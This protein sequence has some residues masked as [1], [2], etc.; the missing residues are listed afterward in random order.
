MN[1]DISQEYLCNLGVWVDDVEVLPIGTPFTNQAGDIPTS[2]GGMDFFSISAD[3]WYYLD[4]ICYIQGYDGECNFLNIEELEAERISIYPNPVKDLLR[5]DNTSTTEIT[6][7]KLYDV[8]GR[9]VLTEKEN[10]DQIDVS[11]LDSGIQFID[12]ETEQGTV[13]KKIIKE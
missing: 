7:I 12:I 3:N 9:L 6:S 2:L 4:N 10:V 8:L 5:I 11:H 13:I 1:W